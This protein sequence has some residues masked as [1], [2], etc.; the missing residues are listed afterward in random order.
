MALISDTWS[1]FIHRQVINIHSR[2]AQNIFCKSTSDT[3]P[4]FKKEILRMYVTDFNIGI[5]CTYMTNLTETALVFGY[6]VMKWTEY[7]VSF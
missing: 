7:S 4:R 6:N 2:H 5:I 3:R 1:Y